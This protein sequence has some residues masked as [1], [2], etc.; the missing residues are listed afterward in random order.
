MWR[1]AALCPLWFSF[2]PT[3]GAES[4][5]ESFCETRPG[6]HQRQSFLIIFLSCFFLLKGWLQ[7]FFLTF[8]CFKKS[9]AVFPYVF[10]DFAKELREKKDAIKV[11]KQTKTSLGTIQWN[12]VKGGAWRTGHGSLPVNQILAAADGRIKEQLRVL[13]SWQASLPRTNSG[14]SELAHCSSLCTLHIWSERQRA[15]A[16]TNRSCPIV[17]RTSLYWWWAA[18]AP[19]PTRLK[20]G[21]QL[22]SVAQQ[23]RCESILPNYGIWSWTVKYFATCWD[24]KGMKSVVH[25]RRGDS[26]FLRAPIKMEACRFT[27]GYC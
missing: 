23:W 15:R 13:T 27:G 10:L 2:S 5:W 11:A 8:A 25:S 4:V 24:S 9:A 19:D 17:P 12:G 7:F 1:V 26:Q 21:W 14:C 22:K 6:S 3:F 20:D 16:R 18:N